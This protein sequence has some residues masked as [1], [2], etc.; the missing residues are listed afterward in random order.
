MVWD[1]QE[2]IMQEE[3]FYLWM[4]NKVKLQK[5]RKNRS[6]SFWHR[7]LY[8]LWHRLSKKAKCNALKLLN[9]LSLLYQKVCIGKLQEEDSHRG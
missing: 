1:G 9:A 4:D 7:E 3:S 6:K 2:V 5:T 8:E